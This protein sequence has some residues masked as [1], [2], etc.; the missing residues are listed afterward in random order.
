[1]L[2]HPVEDGRVY[3]EDQASYGD[4]REYA[5]YD[6][7]K[8]VCPQHTP[9]LVR[10]GGCLSRSM[11]SAPASERAGHVVA[12]LGEVK[13]HRTGTALTSKP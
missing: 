1:M 8:L 2:R 12:A 13:M 7:P 5:D 6:Q 3:P 10:A 9:D 11:T 4:N